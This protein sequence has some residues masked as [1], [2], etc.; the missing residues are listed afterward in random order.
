MT[1]EMIILWERVRLMESGVIGKTGRQFVIQD[2]DG[3]DRVL[4]E[5]EV[6]HTFAHWKELGYS[7]K[8]G[9]HAVASFPIWKGAERVVKDD[10]GKE[11]DEKT[12]KMFMKTSFFFSAAQVEPLTERAPKRE[13]KAVSKGRSY[14]NWLS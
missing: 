14:G 1:N 3:N 2:K 8:K 6:I 12:V 4:D 9:E 10:D 13:R 11:T 7:V 5:P